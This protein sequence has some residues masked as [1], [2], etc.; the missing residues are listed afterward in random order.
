MVK[1]DNIAISLLFDGLPKRIG[2]LVLNEN[3]IYFRYNA[4]F[5]EEKLNLSPFKLP[6]NNAITT[7]PTLPFSGLY[8]VFNDSLPDGWGRLLLDRS[9]QK[10]G[11]NPANISPLDRLAFIGKNG[12]GALIYEPEFEESPILN[13]I[14]DLDFIQ[15]EM[16]LV[17]EGESTE[18]IDK[19]FNLGGSSGGAR[20][21]ISI[22]YN[23]VTKHIISGNQ[24]L[25]D[26]YEHWIIKFSSSFDR[27]DAAQIEFVYYKMA[28]EAGLEM[29]P[30][31]LFKGK[32]GRYYFG[33]KRFDRINNNRIHLHSASGLLH[34]DFRMS[35]LDYGHLMDTA[36]QL[37]KNVSAYDT[38]LRLAAFN[39]Y[40]N[41]RDD[42]SKNFSFLMDE[43]GKWKFAPVY[44]LTFSTSSFGSHSTSIAGEYKNPTT[45]HL[46]ELAKEFG[47]KNPKPIIE[48]VK[49]AV[50]K[51]EQ[52]AKL[53]DVSSGSLK[54]IEKAI[55]SQLF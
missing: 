10:K 8:G 27:N 21:K 49:H 2:E 15:N 22:S 43:K 48:K 42:H 46:L 28:L 23:P 40:S 12:M 38:I 14:N 32:S 53:H 20:P 33:T 1:T 24:N 5:L 55:A 18:I 47:I 16:N 25:P 45:R 29:M 19:L 51:W 7:A 3:K 13:E 11:I 37:E 17:L 26:G 50:S 30:C 31:E 4:A 41:N 34:D 39:L 36:F 54:L 9:L 44:D 6:F 52:I 35:T